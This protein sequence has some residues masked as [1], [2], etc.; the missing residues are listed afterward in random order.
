MK[1]AILRLFLLGI[2][3]TGAMGSNVAQ[4]DQCVPDP[5]VICPAIYSPVIC[6]NGVTYSNSCFASA[7]CA[8]GCRPAGGV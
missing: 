6:N 1:K 8:K 2:A 5:N 4:A 7:A 3:V